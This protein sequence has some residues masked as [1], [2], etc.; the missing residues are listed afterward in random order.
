MQSKLSSVKVMSEAGGDELAEGVV[1]TGEAR[2]CRVEVKV[3][4]RVMRYVDSLW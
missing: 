4:R 1:L 3:C 2:S